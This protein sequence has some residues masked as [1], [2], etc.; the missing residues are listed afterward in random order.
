M[1]VFKFGG[2][3]IKDADAVRNLANIIKRFNA[4]MIIV[5]SAMGKTTN[6]MEEVTEYYFNNNPKIHSA[7]ENVKSYHYEILNNLFPD[8]GT[9]V[10]GDIDNIFGKLKE[11]LSQEHSFQYNFEYDQIVPTGEI[12]STKIVDAYLKYAGINSVW[13]DIRKY[14]KTDNNF[15]EAN[16]DWELSEKLI[17]KAF[18]FKGDEVYV[19]QGFIASTTSN[20]ST[21]LGREGS[22]Y[23]AAIIA[24][25][26]DIKD[27]TIWKDVSGVR[28]AD[29]KYFDNTVK[30]D[31][32]SYRD[33]IELA[34]YGTSVIH[35]KTIQPLQRKN[36][37]LY[38]K[39][40]YNP[41]EPGTI[42]GDDTYERLIP[43]FIFKLNQ[44]LIQI[45]PRD[46]SFI[47]ENNL[48]RIFGCFARYGL[49][50]NLMQNTAINFKVC[51][52]ND[53]TRINPVLKD[54]RKDYDVSYESDLE[55]I[56]IRYYD[57]KTINRTMVNKELLLEQRSKETIQMVVRD[58]GEETN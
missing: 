17:R 32:I 22:D 46:F 51:V 29:P 26:L 4:P 19:T 16:I 1:I 21:T 39:S 9:P 42:V 55:L 6:A 48:E 28:N 40:F 57:E 38:I 31:K 58:I 12:L 35:P 41:E 54:L 3:S 47:S 11:K 27:I 23:T 8:K 49:K 50:I 2:A 36:I 56:T 53:R 10:F 30:L 24:Y 13:T 7:L 18:N 52:N 33:A 5:I 34:Y 15:R 25:M 37:K 14:L 44:V 43:S 20:L 45:Y